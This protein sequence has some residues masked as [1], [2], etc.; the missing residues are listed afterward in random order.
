MKKKTVEFQRAE[1][2]IF[3]ALFSVR[4]FGKRH[5]TVKDFA[6]NPLEYRLFCQNEN[7]GKR[8]FQNIAEK[9]EPK[10]TRYVLSLF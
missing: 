10:K 7:P 3:S 9:N 5:F 1:N 2:Q 4:L 8:F 6:K